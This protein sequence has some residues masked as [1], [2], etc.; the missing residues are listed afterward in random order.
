MLV[1]QIT[2]DLP[3]S[4][5]M[6]ITFFTI[7]LYMFLLSYLRCE[8]QCLESNPPIDKE[9]KAFKQSQKFKQ[10]TTENKTKGILVKIRSKPKLCYYKPGDFGWCHVEEGI[11]KTDKKKPSWGYCSFHCHLPK[12]SLSKRP[13]SAAIR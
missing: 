2:Q 12:K 8:G 13:M 6:N 4:A 1:G 3:D 9:C 5:S 11:T 10:M 7:Q